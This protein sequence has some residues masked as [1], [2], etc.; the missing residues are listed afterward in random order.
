MFLEIQSWGAVYYRKKRQEG[1]SH[2]CALRCLSQR[3]LKILFRMILDHKS[4]DADLHAR[5][6][7]KHGS[8]VLSLLNKPTAKERGNF[9]KKPLQLQRTTSVN[10]SARPG[11]GQT[12][13]LSLEHQI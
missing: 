12:E 3:L 7:E 1:K 2:A 9:M 4:Y 8:W 5:N 11:H 13:S 6:Q 10:S